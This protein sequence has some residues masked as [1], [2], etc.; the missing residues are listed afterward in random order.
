MS[1]KEK[2]KEKDKSVDKNKEDVK[3]PASKKKKSPGWKAHLLLTC[4]VICA[5]LFIPTTVILL[6]GMLPT[7]VAAYTD[8][9]KERM[10]G[11]TIGAMN[12]AGCTP[13][14]MKLWTTE[15][16]LDNSLNILS[17]PMTWVIMYA[18]AGIGYC[19]EWALVGSVSVFMVERANLRIKSI[20]KKQEDL[21]E[22]WGA[23]VSG[24]IPLDE[25]GFPL[26]EEELKKPAPAEPNP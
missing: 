18:G 26:S 16:T 11:I 19:I 1:D 9:T 12:I 25:S 2:A 13:F 10:R 15:H 3:K 4:F 6:A 17:D 8:R 14:I 24:D 23:E 5:V 7:F 22:R 21:I 20:N